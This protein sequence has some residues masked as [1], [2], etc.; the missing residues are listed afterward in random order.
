[1]VITVEVDN[2]AIMKEDFSGSREFGGHS[3]LENF[4]EDEDP[5]N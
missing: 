1:M 5:R 4:K 3:L 2:F